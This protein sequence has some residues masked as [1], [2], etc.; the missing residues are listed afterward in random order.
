MAVISPIIFRVRGARGGA[1][2]RRRN[3]AGSIPDYVFGI[4]NLHNPSRRSSLQQK[5]VPGTPGR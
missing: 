1:V 3:V 4:F 2:G 5:W